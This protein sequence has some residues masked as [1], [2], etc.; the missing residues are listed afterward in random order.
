MCASA[1]QT[2]RVVLISTPTRPLYDT[3]T[4]LQ[5]AKTY[6]VSL[7]QLTEVILLTMRTRR[8]DVDDGSCVHRP[9]ERLTQLSSIRSPRTVNEKTDRRFYLPLVIE[10]M[11][12]QALGD[13]GATLA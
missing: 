6:P 11:S 5:A 1:C 8:G 9:I 7:P 2:F 12:L 4:A 10:G 3:R 13:T